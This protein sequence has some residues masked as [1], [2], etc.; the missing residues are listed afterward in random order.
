MQRFL[1]DNIYDLP[2]V[3]EAK[4]PENDF[5]SSKFDTSHH[6]ELKEVLCLLSTPRSGSTLFCDLVY[7]NGGPILHEYFQS[8]RYMSIMA[9]RWGISRKYR[10]LPKFRRRIQ[11]RVED[12]FTHLVSN[13][14][15]ESGV[16][17]INLHGEHLPNFLKAKPFF[18][19]KPITYLMIKR[20]DVLKQA[21]SFHIALQTKIWSSA[22]GEPKVSPIYSYEGIKSALLRIVKQN[23]SLDLYVEQHSLN[24]EEIYYED[25][26]EDMALVKRCLSGEGTLKL[27]QVKVQTNSYNQEF[28]E[29]FKKKFQYERLGNLADY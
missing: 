2:H 19:N 20:K 25:L 22:F 6:A 10:K 29:R 14:V 16:L 23:A 11:V 12:Y 26:I 28:L 18:Q 15:S 8:N 21:V 9:Q 3:D 24:V 7:R 4:F 27:P 13:R 17:G 5:A 1:D